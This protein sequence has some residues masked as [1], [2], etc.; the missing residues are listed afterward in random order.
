MSCGRCGN[1]QVGGTRDYI[2]KDKVNKLRNDINELE[3]CLIAATPGP[4]PGPGPRPCRCC[5]CCCCHHH[6]QGGR[7]GNQT[8]WGRC[9]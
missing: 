4:G 6:H 2:C 9:N 5:H 3:R 1:N 8:T 7:V